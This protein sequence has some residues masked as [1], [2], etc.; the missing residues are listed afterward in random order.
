MDR[1]KD[2]SPFTRNSTKVYK[3]YLNNARIVAQSGWFTAHGFSTS[4]NRFVRLNMNT[5][6]KKYL[7]K[8]IVP[9]DLKKELMDKLNLLGINNEMLFPDVEGVCKQLNYENKF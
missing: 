8:V 9:K 1:K 2:K 6:L 3:P 4:S 5:S 7:T